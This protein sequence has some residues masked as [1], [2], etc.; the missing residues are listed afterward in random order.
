MIGASN[1]LEFGIPVAHDVASFKQSSVASDTHDIPD[2]ETLRPIIDEK[3]LEVSHQDSMM[4]DEEMDP[5]PAET[6]RSEYS[7]INSIEFDPKVKITGV[8]S[9][10]FSDGDISK[11][12][13]MNEFEIN[14]QTVTLT[15]GSGAL[16]PLNNEVNTQTATM[17]SRIN[18][19]NQAQVP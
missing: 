14:R 18:P 5:L 12:A 2:L 15:D 10:D 19:T 8:N 6:K 11:L 3:Y 1:E 16:T 7:I 4:D 17:D 13:H 9:G